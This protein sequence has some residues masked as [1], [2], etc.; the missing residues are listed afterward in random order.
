MA[1]ASRMERLAQLVKNYKE[2]GAYAKAKT[3]EG[4]KIAGAWAEVALAVYNGLPDEIKSEYDE[5]PLEYL[6]TH[7]KNAMRQG[8]IKY[9]IA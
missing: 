9:T 3:I 5:K 6:M 4:I 7:A 1:R 8:K 2:E